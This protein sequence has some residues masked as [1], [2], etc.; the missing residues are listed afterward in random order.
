MLLGLYPW[1][2]MLRAEDARWLCGLP[3]GPPA[4]PEASQPTFQPFHSTQSTC[5]PLEFS[6][7][8][9]ASKA[10]FGSTCSIH[11]VSSSTTSDPQQSWAPAESPLE[12]WALL[13]G[14]QQSSQGRKQVPW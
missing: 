8:K 4:W 9:F 12:H 7:W 13:S 14:G 1:W 10:L 5:M 2:G 11:L 3:D 6:R